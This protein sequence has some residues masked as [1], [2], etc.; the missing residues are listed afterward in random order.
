MA[1]IWLR[2][3][4]QQ[5]TLMRLPVLPA[6]SAA[7]LANITVV[8][9]RP[10]QPRNIGAAARAL[11]CMGL[12]ALT[13]VRPEHYPDPQADVLA[14]SAIDVL[15]RAQVCSALEQALTG[16]T[17]IYGI[18]ARIRRQR[19]PVRS[20]RHAAADLLAQAHSGPICLVFGNEE[21]GLDNAE[22]ALCQQQLVIPSDPECPSLNLAAAVQVVCHELYQAALELA[23]AHG[24]RSG[25]SAAALDQFCAVANPLIEGCG[26]YANKN[27]D[28]ARAD[29]R[30]L[31]ERSKASGAELAM[32]LGL[33]RQLGRGRSP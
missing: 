19:L 32:L 1:R 15:A 17:Q 18:S 22:L 6:A 8:L 4:F 26:Y 11:K 28:A 16:A 23:P 27:S 3:V 21:A 5:E 13:L 12:R 25:A 10:S 31:L 7:A 2:C 29:L 24:Q 14:V 9:V 20:V 33:L 30:V